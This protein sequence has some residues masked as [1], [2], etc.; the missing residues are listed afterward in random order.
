MIVDCLGH[1]L[2]ASVAEKNHPQGVGLS[3]FAV[4]YGKTALE[5]KI[6]E[7]IDALD[8]KNVLGAIRRWRKIGGALEARAAFSVGSEMRY[9]A[10]R[11]W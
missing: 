4:K 3:H 11:R 6:G 7:E 10:L 1:L 5:E 8:S 9:T 2:L